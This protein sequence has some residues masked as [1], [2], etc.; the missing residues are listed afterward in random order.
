[1]VLEE[2]G[3]QKS[4]Q[5]NEKRLR[6]HGPE[7]YAQLNENGTKIEARNR[8]HFEKYWKKVSQK[9]CEQKGAN[10]QIRV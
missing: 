7:R 10:R 2:S 3:F 1:M 6:K 5:I 4:M 9:R 8:Q